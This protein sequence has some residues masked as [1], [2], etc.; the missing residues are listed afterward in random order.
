MFDP[1]I[2]QYLLDEMATPKSERWS[3]KE[4]FIN[5]L[6]DRFAAQELD[7][8]GLDIPRFGAWL[9]QNPLRCLGLR[10]V[11]EAHH[12]R[13]RDKARP[14]EDGDIADYAHITAIPYVDLITVDKRIA[15][16][17]AK[18]FR[19]LRANHLETDLSSKGFARVA[20]LVATL[21]SLDR[22]L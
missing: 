1:G 4:I 8:H 20:D 11:F 16:L 14:F 7:P 9:W 21:S 3:L 6:P 17:L 5:R 12:L 2:K 19:K 18:T 13:Q 10:L 22:R 15:H